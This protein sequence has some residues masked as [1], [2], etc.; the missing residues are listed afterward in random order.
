MLNK[1]PFA[2]TASDLL[3]DDFDPLATDD[4]QST[5]DEYDKLRIECPV[6]RTSAYGSYWLLTRYEDVKNAA[7][8]HTTFISSVK[9]VV[10][11]DP[12]GLRR[13]PLNF[14][15]PHHGPYR[16]ALEKTLSPRRLLHLERPLEAQAEIE[17]EKMLAKGGGDI[18]AE[19]GACFPAW[20]E[21]LWLNLDDDLAP[22]LAKTAS[23]WVNGWRLMDRDATTRNS[24]ILYQLAKDLVAD[25][26]VNLRDPEE[27]P[28]SSLLLERT[29]EGEPL[30]E[31]HIIGAVRQSLVVGMVAP[32]VILGSVCRHLS[33]D[34]KLQEKLR[35]EPELIPAAVEEFVRLYSPYRGFARTPSQE[36]QL[37]DRILRPG[38]PVTM[39]YASANRDPEHWNSPNEFI[40]HRPNLASHLGFGIGRH[41]CAGRP[42]AR[43][44]L[45]IALRV[46][47]KSTTKF[48][49][50]GPFTFARMPEV[51]LT[52]CPLAMYSV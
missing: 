31:E 14:D 13:P 34:Q 44:G 6:A 24:E 42:L 41:Q 39:T 52:G 21:A 18:C 5:F 47:L 30:L 32:P 49:V 4:P 26:K 3:G 16:R 46:L 43:M 37:H 36:V 29:A 15:A 10:P 27:D 20:M 28:V 17:L 45:Q 23:E 1:C 50:N 2:K 25:R 38:E 48:E 19:F 51:G 9:A 7:S 35:Q 11:S 22:L 8:D 12:R 33:E 40:L